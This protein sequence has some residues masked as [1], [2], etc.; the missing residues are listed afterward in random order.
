M[1]RGS[2]SRVCSLLIAILLSPCRSVPED[3]TRGDFVA[4]IFLDGPVDFQDDLLRS[5]PGSTSSGSRMGLC[6]RL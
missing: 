4:T 3:T 2:E 6:L 1:M 5:G